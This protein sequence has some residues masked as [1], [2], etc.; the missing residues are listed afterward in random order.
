MVDSK[1]FN[2]REQSEEIFSVAKDGGYSVLHR[3]DSKAEGLEPG[4][5]VVQ[6]RNG[7]LYGTTSSGGQFD[8]GTIFRLSTDG[9][10]YA[11][12]HHF[13]GGDADG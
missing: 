6:G 3:F 4:S 9:K 13:A 11:V 7:A 1:R 8:G 12:L 2:W 5:G 10:A